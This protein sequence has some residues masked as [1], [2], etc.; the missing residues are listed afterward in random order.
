[1]IEVLRIKV[2]YLNG[3]N[4]VKQVDLPKQKF[5]ENSEQMEIDRFKREMKLQY[6]VNKR[7]L[8]ENPHSTP[9]D[10]IM[11]A[12]KVSVT[13]DIKCKDGYIQPN[14]IKNKLMKA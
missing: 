14:G 6:K 7:Y 2:Q 11:H 12:P 13:M 9:D 4:I 3:E 5:Y 1:M 10:L 8:E